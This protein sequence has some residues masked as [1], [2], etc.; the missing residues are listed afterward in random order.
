MSNRHY[1]EHQQLMRFVLSTGGALA[2]P[3]CAQKQSNHAPEA[4]HKL[5]SLAGDWQGKDEQAIM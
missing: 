5:Q 2:S 1:S 4:F 3:L